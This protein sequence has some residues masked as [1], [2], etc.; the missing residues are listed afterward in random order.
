M[1]SDFF[2]KYL[3]NNDFPNKNYNAITS[4]PDKNYFTQKYKKKFLYSQES[5]ISNSESKKLFNESFKYVSTFQQNLFQKNIENY[6]SGGFAQKLYSTLYDVKNDDKILTTKDCDI[7]VYYD[8]IKINNNVILTNTINI[9]DSVINTNKLQDYA[10]IKLYMLI[11][12]E[13]KKKFDD[14]IKIF[15]DAKFDLYLYLIKENDYEFRFL[16]LINKEL[17]I[18]LKI[19]VLNLDHLIKEKIYSYS[20]ITYYYTEKLSTVN[21]YIPIEILVKSKEKSNIDIMKSSIN[22][23]N[24]VYYLYNLN[25]ILYNLMHLYYKYNY[26]T[27]DITI[28]KKKEEKKNIRDKKRLDL[29]F[30]IYCKALYPDKKDVNILFDKLK[31]NEKKFKKNIDKIKN[32]DMIENIFN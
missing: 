13:N 12:Y 17:C 10:F 7:Y 4:H 18:I 14:I 26:N 15:I 25:T 3:K 28:T 27:E 9:I 20:K 11:N 24:R 6:I 16:K 1:N 31:K 8:N 23:Y 19:K 32:F 5:N 30:K 2:I 22:I 29:F 21:K